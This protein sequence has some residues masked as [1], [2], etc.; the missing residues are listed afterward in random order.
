LKSLSQGDFPN[1]LRRRCEH[2]FFA[3]ANPYWVSSEQSP[4]NDSA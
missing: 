1:P 3:E 4:G 2:S